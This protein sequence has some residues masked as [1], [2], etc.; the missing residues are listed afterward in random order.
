MARALPSRYRLPQKQ[1]S[2]PSLRPLPRRK[3]RKALVNTNSVALL[4]AMSQALANSLKQ[5]LVQYCHDDPGYEPVESPLSWEQVYQAT[6]QIKDTPNY[7]FVRKLTGSLGP[8]P[9]SLSPNQS[10]WAHRIAL[11]AM[12][13]NLTRLQAPVLNSPNNRALPRK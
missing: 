10:Y 9:T 4:N 8:T 3:G 6:Q 7:S 12:F 11:D 2:A 13:R 1:N 5:P